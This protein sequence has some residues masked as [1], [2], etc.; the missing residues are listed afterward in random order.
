M[1]YFTADL[2]FSHSGIIEYDDR[3]FK[4][5]REMEEKLIS[6]WNDTVTKKDI[7]Y[8]LGDFCWGSPKMAIKILSQLKGSIHL[9]KGN[10]DR[11]NKELES[12]FVTV[13]WQKKIKVGGRKYILSHY[14]FRTWAGQGKGTYNIHGHCHGN[15]EPLPDAIDVGCNLWDYRPASMDEIYF[16]Y[17]SKNEQI[18]E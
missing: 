18:M 11:L 2:H 16:G 7:V 14:P 4:D 6:N 8:L 17:R 9:I 10:H 1:R 5:V 3:P 12:L 13:S 15:L